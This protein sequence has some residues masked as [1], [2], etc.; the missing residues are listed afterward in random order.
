MTQPIQK[1]ARMGK[2]KK[3]KT[4][5]IVVLVGRHVGISN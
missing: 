5:A 4:D 2:L 3:T 1:E